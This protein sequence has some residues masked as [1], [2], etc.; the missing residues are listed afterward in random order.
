MQS[1]PKIQNVLFD[2]A[3]R[4]EMRQRIQEEKPAGK[5]ENEE[6]QV[7]EY[8]T[9]EQWLEVMNAICREYFPDADDYRL[10][11]P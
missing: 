6:G 4:N 3:F 9:K 5:H 1:E 10:V 7:Q 8:Y 2:E 11:Q